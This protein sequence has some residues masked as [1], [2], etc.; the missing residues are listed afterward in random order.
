MFLALIGFPEG[1][2]SPGKL[3][4]NQEA[5]KHRL[6]V[7]Y[8][9]TAATLLGAC[10]VPSAPKSS[11]LSNFSGAD[12]IKRS[13][14]RTNTQGGLSISD[15]EVSAVL[16]NRKV[17]HRD[18]RADLRI[19]EGDQPPFLQRIK[20]DIEQQIQTSGGRI[21]D[22]GSGKSNYSIAYTSSGATGWID[23]WG[24]R[25]TSDSYKVVIIITESQEL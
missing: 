15:T 11:F 12:S 19:S 1:K 13:Y 22:E 6:L 2:G 17:Y 16:G 8:G 18:D 23:V 24:M 5:V 9:I 14:E 3:A 20:E 4:G 7:I 10:S 21:V 25:E